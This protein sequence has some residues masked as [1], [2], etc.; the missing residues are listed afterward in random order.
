MAGR[1]TSLAQAWRGARGNPNARR[2][3]AIHV[4]DCVGNG[5]QFSTLA[6]YLNRQSGLSVWHIGLGLAIG[7]A[8]GLVSN[9][10]A[11]RLSDT[12]G[13]RRLLSGLLVSLGV[14]FFLLP[15]VHGLGGF[16]V[17]S[18]PYSLLHFS[19]GAPFMSLI[20]EA[21]GMQER[22]RGRAMIRSFGNAGMAL[23][24]AA[25]VILLAVTSDAFLVV[26]PFVNGASF[27][28]AGLMVTRLSVGRANGRSSET[29]Q[30]TG[31]H[32]AFEPGMP[33]MIVTTSVLGLHSSLL[34]VG[35]PLW[36]SATKV[37]PPW[38]IPV[39]IGLNTVLVVAFQV[40]AVD[41]SGGS[42]RT[43]VSGSR[44]AGVIGAAGCAVLSLSLWPRSTV[45]AAMILLIGFLLLTA[46]ELLQNGAAFYL[47]LNLG[48]DDRRGEYASAFH[49][50]QIVEGV[51][52][53]F[54]IGAAFAGAHG[55]SWL[56]FTV[57]LLAASVVY[58]HVAGR[59][60]HLAT[61]PRPA[62]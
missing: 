28:L 54:L 5:V 26:S 23:G 10:V 34:A 60:A 14:V 13:G 44:L 29:T 33:A 35:I 39:L 15:L 18:I 38:T 27:L 31:L 36:I 3:V 12:W 30:T 53:P 17:F 42:F 51:L 55:S 1:S 59:V 19:C 22:A 24:A 61:D 58:R 4:V 57:G 62:S 47:G 56:I 8:F 52:G 37:V 43:A 25:S 45:L 21:F 49:V 16:V 2:L 40:A 32:A 6:L 48:P 7:G 46:T 11:G 41:R 50:T 20:G 9:L